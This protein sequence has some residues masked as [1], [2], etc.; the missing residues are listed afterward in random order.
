MKKNI[1]TIYGFLTVLSVSTLLAIA[2]GI[3][4]VGNTM[5]SDVN[6]NHYSLT[7]AATVSATNFSGNGANLTNLTPGAATSVPWAG[8][9]GKPTT[10]TGYGITNLAPVATSGLYSD[11]TGKPTIPA[12]Q[13]NSDWNASS[14]VA[15][16][17]NKPNGLT[18][19][20]TL[21][22]SFGA[23]IDGGNF[24]LSNLTD[25]TA[26]TFSGN[27]TGL[28][29]LAAGNL[30]SGTVPIA[31]LGSS[32]TPSS[33]T[34]L[35]G[36]NS[37]TALGTAAL[38]D[39]S[40]FDA[41]GAAASAQAASQPLDSDLTAIA[42]LTTTAYGRSLLTGADAGATRTLLG[43]GTLSTQSGTFSGASSGTNTGDQTA[44]TGLTL[45][46]GAFSVNY[47]SS[48]TTATVGNDARLPA[49][50]T[51]LRKSSGAGSTDVA[52]VQSDLTSLISGF[53]E[54]PL[55]FSNGLTR[56]VNAIA[57]TY[58]TTSGT[59]AQGNDSR[60]AGVAD[61]YASVYGAKADCK[62]VLDAVFTS[63]SVT[64]TSAT[65]GFTSADTGKTFSIPN[66]TNI[67]QVLT[68]TYVNATT[69]TLSSTATASSTGS[70][71][72][73]VYYGTNDYTAI[74]NCIQA[75]WTAG[76]NAIF[77]DAIYMVAQG[78]TGTNNAIFNIPNSTTAQRTPSILGSGS[79]GFAQSTVG[80]FP[81]NSG[82]I[83][84]CPNTTV[85]GTLPAV[86]AC[87][88]WNFSG[89]SFGYATT[90]AKIRGITIRQPANPVLTGIQWLKG[91]GLDVDQFVCD[92]DSKFYS[93]PSPATGGGY[94][95]ICPQINNP[96]WTQLKNIYIIGYY[97]GIELGE[98]ANGD[99]I[100]IDLC[101][102]GISCT[103]ATSHTL[104]LTSLC[105]ARCTTLVAGTSLISAGDWRVN[106][107]RLAIERT[108]RATAV[109]T[110][111]ISSYDIDDASNH[112]LA[113]IANL[114][115]C[116][117]DDGVVGSPVINGGLY[118]S[119]Y[120]A[121]AKAFIGNS[122][123][124]I[125]GTG[126]FAN[127][128]GIA[129]GLSSTSFNGG[130]TLG[131]SSQ[132][133]GGGAVGPNA[134]VIDSGGGGGGGAVGNTSQADTGGAVGK[135]SFATTGFAG[136]QGA[137]ATGGGFNFGASTY[138][139]T[140]LAVFGNE[141]T[142]VNGV[143]KGG[144]TAT[145]VSG[146]TSGQIQGAMPIRGTTYKKVIIYCSALTGT[147]QYSFPTNF[148]QVPAIITT[149]GLAAS[150]VTSLGGNQA[151]L[152]GAASTGWIILEGF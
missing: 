20:E 135:S 140:G 66:T 94:G 73:S 77:D 76:G 85:S 16:I 8:V 81:S 74:N 54:S 75:A 18:Y 47:G 122:N 79:Y 17:L 84:W 125:M 149:N 35:R 50:M 11:L 22:Q 6:G 21:T 150:V 102:R 45:T 26:A 58:G 60:I 151:T 19:A 33:T 31:R 49:S 117:T 41:A 116:H 87:V 67:P 9:T 89:G 30:S 119:Y 1:S 13:V 72:G 7:N 142:D 131:T 109:P 110:W 127:G 68:G 29:G 61:F 64:L 78:A 57:P 100:F 23:D 71:I 141:V 90:G 146:S 69:I 147:A 138:S 137:R 59:V 92:T 106:I 120:D 91:G 104:N 32:G 99:G 80:M 145:I 136:G 124:L 62:Q 121:W 114:I 152:T 112:M 25:V 5:T 97:E 126:S 82:T 51:G 98:H 14:G 103:A 56:T 53:Y 101:Y 118:V 37:W 93:N 48:S 111:A 108:T 86:F 107:G 40:F 4:P 70:I 65:A 44:G 129:L 95:I 139:G 63:G 148:S 143:L 132:S 2:A 34:F 55:T 130:V 24:N 133:N 83:F 12:A 28:T 128:H 46:T 38:H 27:G 10:T 113:N 42:A 96:A 39:V 3:S 105:I 36:D 52:A 144:G 43:L 115:S 88:P 15:Q 134:S 123:N